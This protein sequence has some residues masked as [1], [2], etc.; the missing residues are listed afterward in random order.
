MLDK[1]TKTVGI[2][3]AA[4]E[5]YRSPA[6]L[7]SFGKDSMVLLHLLRSF[8]LPVICHI[9]PYHPE[10]WM[11]AREMAAKM[12]L[13]VFSYP[14]EWV[15]LKEH[16]D[17][18]Y[19]ASGYTAGK[20]EIRVIYQRIEHSPEGIC[21]LHDVL[22][23][24]KGT[25]LNQWDLMI[26]AQKDGDPG[27][28]GEMMKMESTLHQ[29]AS[30]VDTLFPMRDWTEQDIYRYT[31][32]NSIPI[33]RDRYTVDVDNGVFSERQNHSYNPDVATGCFACL[34]PGD[35]CV[36]CPRIGGIEVSRVPNTPWLKEETNTIK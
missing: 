29:T 27:T 15:A 8:K 7:V 11:F 33:H 16:N 1:I 17:K 2:V 30:G 14:P 36:E 12:K 22:R 5:K 34:M 10:R 3:Q 19:V 9:P 23:Q 26:C 25:M 18:H 24:P 20:G 32:S 35:G 31:L 4:I 6:L 21:G 13:S 28:G